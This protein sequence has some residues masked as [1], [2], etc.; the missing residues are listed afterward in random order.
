MKAMK[1]VDD[2]WKPF[3]LYTIA[4]TKLETCYNELSEIAKSKRSNMSTGHVEV[5]VVK[6]LINSGEVG[7]EMNYR[8]PPQS[9]CKG[10]RRPQRHKHPIEKKMRT[11]S[12]CHKK[13]GHNVR[14]CQQVHL[15]IQFVFEIHFNLYQYY[16]GTLIHLNISL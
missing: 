13:A 4:S 15:Y 6:P 9:Q 3:E 16:P 2:F 12:N 7:E 1:I 10:M 14:T 5:T 8:D 11:C